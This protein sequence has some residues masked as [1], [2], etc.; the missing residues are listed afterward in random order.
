MFSFFSKKINDSNKDKDS[1]S[2]FEMIDSI[3]DNNSDISAIEISI[4][5]A[6]N[7]IK[8]IDI[9]TIE[10]QKENVEIFT[11]TYSETGSDKNVNVKDVNENIDLETESESVSDENEDDVNIDSESSTDNEDIIPIIKVTIPFISNDYEGK[12]KVYY[13]YPFNNSPRLYIGNIEKGKRN[14]NGKL[15]YDNEIKEGKFVD[16]ELVHGTYYSNEVKF[17]GNFINDKLYSDVSVINKHGFIFQGM[18]QHD[19]PFLND[20]YIGYD[21]NL[22]INFMGFTGILTDA[23]VFSDPLSTY[24]EGFL[25]VHFEN[26]YIKKATIKVCL[27][28]ANPNK[29]GYDNKFSDIVKFGNIVLQNGISMKGLYIMAN[30]HKDK[31][32]LYIDNPLDSIINL[33]ITDTNNGL[34]FE[35]RDIQ[36]WDNKKL[37]LWVFITFPHFHIDFANNLKKYKITGKE[38][39]HM[40]INPNSNFLLLNLFD[41]T[42][43]YLLKYLGSSYDKLIL[44]TNIEQIKRVVCYISSKPCQ[45]PLEFYNFVEKEFPEIDDVI[46]IFIRNNKLTAEIFKNLN[47]ELL[48]ENFN[49]IKI[50]QLMIKI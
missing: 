1:D 4:K 46:K 29:L 10:D 42:N 48:N 19:I 41:N 22:K 40:T 20:G 5:S 37:I 25:K 13:N 38:F 26:C 49:P 2:E 44:H 9:K 21:K 11:E 39:Y 35:T 33:F 31:D 6:E 8:T 16:N 15:Y 43:E 7:E 28:S 47:F 32:V 34:Q 14:G 3:K 30:V 27:Y 23:K 24:M 36:E 50:F 17:V 18:V 12:Y 45:T